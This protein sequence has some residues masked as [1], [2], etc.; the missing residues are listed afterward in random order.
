M[1]STDLAAQQRIVLR[2]DALSAAR[3]KRYQT[4]RV[5]QNP[6]VFFSQKKV[7]CICAMR[8][9]QHTR[10]SCIDLTANIILILSFSFPNQPL[11]AP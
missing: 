9:L 8:H 6:I 2:P 1:L 4:L 10:I 7:L 11:G 5:P 3:A